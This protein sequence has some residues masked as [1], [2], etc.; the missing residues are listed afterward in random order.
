MKRRRIRETAH[1]RRDVM[2]NQT[3]A[4]KLMV[5]DLKP[6]QEEKVRGGR[7]AGKP[8]VSEIVVTKTTD[9]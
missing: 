7:D 1:T 3:R 4:T 6:R 9:C 2:N 5:A 8:Q